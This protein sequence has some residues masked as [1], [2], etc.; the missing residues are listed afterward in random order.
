MK[1]II[2]TIILAVSNFISQAQQHEGINITVTINN[3]KSDN[4]F[5]LLGLHNQQTFMNRSA[6]AL[7]KKKVTITDGK[8][9]VAFH[10]VLPGEYAVMAIHDENAN[11]QMDFEPNGIPKE[12]YGM[13]NNEMSFGPPAFNDAKFTVVDKNLSLEIRL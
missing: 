7:N 11:N 5:V 10:N 13:S 9:T 6:P 2:L 8:I 4:G 1:T 3:V 12:A